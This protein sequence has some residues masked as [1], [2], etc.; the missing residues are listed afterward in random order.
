MNRKSLLSSTM[1]VA[2]IASVHFAMGAAPILKKEDGGTGGTGGVGG[3]PFTATG[4]TKE[5][6]AADRFSLHGRYF[7][8]RDDWGLVCDGVTDEDAAFSSF[9]AAPLNPGINWTLT[10]PGK[11]LI[12]PTSHE[13]PPNLSLL[14]VNGGGFTFP[15]GANIVLACPAV[16]VAVAGRRKMAARQARAGPVAQDMR[17]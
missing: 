16:A 12:H 15:P 9:L 14:G 13:L 2:L 7:D 1:V 11:C 4:G 10:L 3:T 6:T 17:S 8:A 5:T